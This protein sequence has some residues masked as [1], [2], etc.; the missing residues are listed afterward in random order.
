MLA[1]LPGS[2]GGELKYL[3]EPFARAASLI[4]RRLPEVRFITPLARPGLRPLMQYM[5]ATHAPDSDWTLV[6][7][8]SRQVMQAADTVLLASGTA[9]LECLLVGRPMTVAYRASAFSIWVM[10][11][12]K[13]LLTDHVSLPNLLMQNPCVTELLQEDA[14]PENLANDVL[15][16]LTDEKARQQ[17]LGQFSAVHDRLRCDAATQVV[18]AIERFIGVTDE[19]ASAQP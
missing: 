5:I 16:L 17:Q 3:A 19:S 12:F 9:T 10:R 1:I 4:R 6:D 8:H 7:G 11:Q 13:L 14:S 18:A 15:R 2:R